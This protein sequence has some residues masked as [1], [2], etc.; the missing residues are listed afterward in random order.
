MYFQQVARR[1]VIYIVSL[2]TWAG[3]GRYCLDALPQR[4]K[5]LLPAA[6]VL[7]L[8]GFRSRDFRVLFSLAEKAFSLAADK[9]VRSRWRQAMSG[10]QCPVTLLKSK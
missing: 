8:M 3:T 2:L 10:P 5:H 4:L 9:L 1:L 6:G 7:D